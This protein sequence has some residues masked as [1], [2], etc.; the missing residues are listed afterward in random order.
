MG[1]SPG[2]ERQF[3]IRAHRVQGENHGSG[4][5]GPVEVPRGVAPA[6]R[7][8]GGGNGWAKLLAALGFVPWTGFRRRATGLAPRLPEGVVVGVQLVCT[9]VALPLLRR[10]GLRHDDILLLVHSLGR[11]P[12]PP[13]MGG[14]TEEDACA[15]AQ[16][17][18][19]AV[20]SLT[21]PREHFNSLTAPRAT[22]SG[23]DAGSVTHSLDTVTWR[24]TIHRYEVCP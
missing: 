8:S 18:S 16:M 12:Y 19:E 7:T 1:R 14:R 13:R 3:G 10:F 20:P 6:R 24:V 23:K 17:G 21:P 15:D 9:V 4:G 22:L 5:P 11:P 2:A